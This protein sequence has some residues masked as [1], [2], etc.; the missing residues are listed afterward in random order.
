MFGRVAHDVR[1]P[2]TPPPMG[3]PLRTLFACAIG[4]ASLASC[5]TAPA[6]A[7]SPAIASQAGQEALDARARLGGAD[8]DVVIRNGRVIDGMGNPW[9]LADVGIIGGKF[10]P[11]PV[12]RLSLNR[13]LY[14][15]NEAARP[16]RAAPFEQLLP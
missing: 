11:T 6:P 4:A 10:A 1:A 12:A 7:P 2:F 14:T 5:R 15:L 3:L 8:Y 16:L 13:L 9:I